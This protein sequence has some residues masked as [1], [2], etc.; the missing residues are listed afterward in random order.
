MR[1]RHTNVDSKKKK[2]GNVV[3]PLGKKG[4]EWESN[5]TFQIPVTLECST[6]EKNR[7]ERLFDSL[8]YIIFI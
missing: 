8:V 3:V 2:G 7:G 4:I 6:T 1:K 5:H